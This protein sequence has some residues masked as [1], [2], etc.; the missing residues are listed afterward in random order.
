[1]SHLERLLFGEAC[2]RNM[3]TH[4]E[5]LCRGSIQLLPKP[6]C[7]SSSGWLPGNP[8]VFK[9][10]IPCA[11][12]FFWKMGPRL[13]WAPLNSRPRQSDARAANEIHARRSGETLRRFWA[14]ARLRAELRKPR[15]GGRV[16]GGEAHPQGAGVQLKKGVVHLFV[17]SGFVFFSRKG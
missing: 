5:G 9:E 8:P 10:Q 13:K 14:A 12:P 17:S 7:S 1:M 16:G 11:A 3:A 15:V 2:K 4:V 6:L